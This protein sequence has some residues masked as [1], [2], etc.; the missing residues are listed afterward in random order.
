MSAAVW[1]R[2]RQRRRRR[3]APFSPAGGISANTDLL[4]W[5][6]ERATG[7]SFAQLMSD[8]LWQPVGA[9]DEAYT[10]EDRAGAL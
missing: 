7:R 8:L 3:A 1:L 4:G 5:V 9:V 10:T 6:V 2:L